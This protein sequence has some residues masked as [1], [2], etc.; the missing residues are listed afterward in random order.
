M[1]WRM[2]N[3]QMDRNLPVVH[4]SRKL[5]ENES[6]CSVAYET[7]STLKFHHINQICSESVQW[8]NGEQMKKRNEL[9][10]N[11]SFSIDQLCDTITKHIKSIIQAVEKVK[12]C[13]I[14]GMFFCTEAS[15]LIWWWG[16]ERA[17]FQVI[18]K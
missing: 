4:M 2:K 1:K 5:E 10:L 16:M 15:T 13:E 12:K 7:H 3:M 6:N 9:E 8:K 14:F 17:Q 18:L 11:G